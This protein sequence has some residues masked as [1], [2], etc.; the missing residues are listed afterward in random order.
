MSGLWAVAIHWF[1][2]E[3]THLSFCYTTMRGFERHIIMTIKAW[4]ESLN[5]I[6]SLLLWKVRLTVSQIIIIRNK[7]FQ[8]LNAVQ[9]SD[10]LLDYPCANCFEKKNWNKVSIIIHRHVILFGRNIANSE[11]RG[12]LHGR[13][14]ENTGSV[15][16]VYRFVVIFRH[17]LSASGYFWSRYILFVVKCFNW[18]FSE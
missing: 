9:N 3:I 13:A 6:L 10:L 16:R 5:H 18:V 11:Y 15:D 17:K 2:L 8:L 14:G 7:L 4:L 1:L 12:W